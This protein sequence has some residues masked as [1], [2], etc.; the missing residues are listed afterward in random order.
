MYDLFCLARHH[1][2]HKIQARDSYKY[3]DMNHGNTLPEWT[4]TPF[5]DDWYRQKSPYTRGLSALIRAC[6]EA[7]PDNRPTA[8]Q[9]YQS[10][11][12]E[13]K[14][15]L[16]KAPSLDPVSVRNDKLY[17]RGNEINDMTVE[18]TNCY[19]LTDPWEYFQLL[20]PGVNG[21]DLPRLRIAPQQVRE[22]VF[23]DNNVRD[24]ADVMDEEFDNEFERQAKQYSYRNN[25]V[26]QG[27]IEKRGDR[28][29]FNQARRLSIPPSPPPGPPRDEKRLSRNFYNTGDSEGDID[30][31]TKR[32]KRRRLD[33]DKAAIPKA[34]D[35]WDAR[36]AGADAQFMGPRPNA[37]A[38]PDPLHHIDEMLGA[39][40]PGN[41]ALPVNPAPVPQSQARDNPA[42]TWSIAQRT[43]RNALGIQPNPDPATL[44][45]G[46]I[47]PPGDDFYR[48]YIRRLQ[49]AQVRDAYGMH[50]QAD[51]DHDRAAA[52]TGNAP[53][54]AGNP[55]VPIP[56]IEADGPANNS[57]HPTVGLG[58]A[59]D[60]TLSLNTPSRRLKTVPR[61]GPLTERT[62]NHVGTTTA[63][64]SGTERMPVADH[65]DVQAQ[66]QHEPA[67][68]SR[69]GP[70]STHQSAARQHDHQ[71]QGRHSASAMSKRPTSET[72][73]VA[74]HGEEIAPPSA[75]PRPASEEAAP[76]AHEESGASPSASNT[77][78]PAAPIIVPPPAR[79]RGVRGRPP[80]RGHGRGR[81]QAVAD[82]GGGRG[83]AQGQRGRG[84]GR[85][86]GSRAAANVVQHVAPQTSEERR[87]VQVELRNKRAADRAANRR[88]G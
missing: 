10:T 29:H 6:M 36:Q 60:R 26:A 20:A 64:V 37:L 2:Y 71:S 57:R 83:G 76:A 18:E 24:D 34:Q 59:D 63:G 42:D 38:N 4:S 46:G 30:N 51:Q 75:S 5:R 9:L 82:N 27:N 58:S 47:P 62:S 16:E 81:G 17:Y 35:H 21:P 74:T 39:V 85:P 88:G 87:A 1:D 14:S 40:G 53:D 8:R 28:I 79:G 56:T 32:Y 49:G 3:H 23:S 73:Q 33:L 19:H 72:A 25:Q 84:R 78:S 67:Q 41:E 15:C 65:H 52:T 13:L 31:M 54:P 12:D 55:D 45:F 86:R 66:A 70:R 61:R 68:R 77:D 11:S 43:S 80:G 22:N 44:A 50:Q 7:N 69:L 48:Q